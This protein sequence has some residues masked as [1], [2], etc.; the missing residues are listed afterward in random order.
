MTNDELKMW[1]A[2]IILDH[3]DDVEFM[4]IGEILEERGVNASYEDRKMIY[5]LITQKADVRVYF[6]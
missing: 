5:D 2:D 6:E 4:S 1:A 3:V